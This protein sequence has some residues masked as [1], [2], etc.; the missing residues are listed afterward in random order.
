MNHHLSMDSDE[1]DL[2]EADYFDQLDEQ[3]DDDLEHP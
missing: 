1:L 2:D 3:D